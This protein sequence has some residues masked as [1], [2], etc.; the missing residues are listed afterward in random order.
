MKI[1]VINP[2]TSRHMTETIDKQ[3]H[4]AASHSTIVTIQP[5][6]GPRGIE[7]QYEEVVSAYLSWE[8]IRSHDYLDADAYLVACYSAHPLIG[9]LRERVT[10]P[11]LGIMEASVIGAMPLGDKFSV[12]TTSKRWEPLLKEGIINLGAG[13]RLASVRSTGMSVCDLDRLPEDQVINKLVNE[14][15]I[16]VTADSAEVLCLGCA[17]MGGLASSLRQATG[18]PIVDGVSV[19]I[20]LLE[21]LVLE[22]LTTSKNGRYADLPLKSL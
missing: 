8:K 10:E 17:G 11:V 22:G 16:A 18:V 21:A 7:S 20:R 9:M 5:D 4:F 1:L 15:Q 3:A 14:A 6:E 2:N 13:G 19:G 12:I